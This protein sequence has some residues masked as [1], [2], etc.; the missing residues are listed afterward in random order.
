MNPMA[1]AFAFYGLKNP[2]SID[3][4]YNAVVQWFSEKD[5][6]PDKL[7]VNG[8]GFSGKPTAFKRTNERLLNTGFQDVESLSI[9][10]ML[11]DG[12]YPLT[13]WKMTATLSVGKCSYIILGINSANAGLNDSSDIVQTT[14]K[15]MKPC[16]GIGY[17]REMEFGPSL[18]AIGINYGMHDVF[19][20]PEYDKKLKISHWGSVGMN[21]AVYERGLL[22]DIYPENFLTKPHLSRTVSGI[23]LK[24]W[25]AEHTN[26]GK[27]TTITD[28]MTLWSIDDSEIDQVRDSLKDEDIIFDAMKHAE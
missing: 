22:R 10:A 26:R 5:C 25:I 9:I 12:E 7:S 24:K 23:P 11:E 14:A 17:Y 20:G 3:S 4:Y 21:E 15:L 16:Y 2:K 13:D 8:K 1:A 18:Y 28:Q 6:L 27:L 19:S